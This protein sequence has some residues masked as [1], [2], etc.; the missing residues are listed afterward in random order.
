MKH[1]ND[2]MT[3]YLADELAPEDRARVEDHCSGCADCA[4]ELAKT[5]E[6]WDLVAAAAVTVDR[7]PRLWEA[8]RERTLGGDEWF[9][10]ARPWTRRGWA[11]GAV[12]A[13]LLMGVLLPGAFSPGEAEAEPVD[14]VLTGSTWD[15]ESTT[16][17]AGW[18]L[19][20]AG[21]EEGDR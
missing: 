16:D 10:G 12:A 3:S 9:F 2:L 5:R 20:D 1:V 14:L 6:A 15:E 18:W 19:E 8:V 7:N 4:A 13:G 17:L 11:T 21:E